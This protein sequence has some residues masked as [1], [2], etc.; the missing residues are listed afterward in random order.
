MDAA[1]FLDQHHADLSPVGRAL[2]FSAMS[3]AKA[4]A[5][6]RYAEAE[7][8]AAGQDRVEALRFA[9]RQGGDPLGGLQVARV[10]FEAADDVC[11][12]LAGKLAK[13][14]AKRD[15]AHENIQFLS[16]RMDEMTTAVS[17]S[18]PSSSSGVEGA[19]SRAQEALREETSRRKVEAMLAAAPPPRQVSR[20][21]GLPKGH[22]A[23][24]EICSAA[25]AR[26]RDT[27]RNVAWEDER[28]L[29]TAH[30][31]SEGWAVR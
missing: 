14:T 24:C 1:D 28:Q 7:R 19:V 11:R 16:R 23:G 29:R 2:A 8:E 15:R 20:S 13:A 6:D 22:E 26:E 31:G 18:A 17:R 3:D 5:E 21:V 30:G 12:D 10:A 9:N 4:D 27:G 25:R